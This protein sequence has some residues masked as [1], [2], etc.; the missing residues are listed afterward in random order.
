[1]TKR[2]RGKQQKLQRQQRADPRAGTSTSPVTGST[3]TSRLP[4]APWLI[5]GAIVLVVLVVG[6]LL[7][8]PGGGA[9]AAS[10]SA[11][12]SPSA[13]HGVNCPTSQPP[14]LPAGETRR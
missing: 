10:A 13:A 5:G 9:G 11:S 6:F 3:V 4:G 2:R 14:P 12:P 8:R 1:M 7:L